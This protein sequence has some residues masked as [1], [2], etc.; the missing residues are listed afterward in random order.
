VESGILAAAGAFGNPTGDLRRI[1]RSL[2]R[3]TRTATLPAAETE[4]P[5][6]YR[7]TEICMKLSRVYRWGLLVGSGAVVFQ[8][9]A[10]SPWFEGLTALFTGVTAGAALW[11]VRNA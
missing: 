1:G 3:A 8:A 6:N 4:S 11:L 9:A 10:C 2:D 5:R 7:H